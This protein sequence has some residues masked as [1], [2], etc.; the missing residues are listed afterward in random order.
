L[1]LVSLF[2]FDF[3]AGW[4][5]YESRLSTDPPVTVER[6]LPMPRFTGADW[7]RSRRLAVWTEQGIGDQVLYSTVVPDLEARGLSFVLEC[8]SRLASAFARAHPS[9]RVVTPEESGKA[10][11]ECDFH[12]PLA[13]LAGLVRPS[14]ASFARQPTRLLTPDPQRSGQARR[15]L[16]RPGARL[17]AISWRSFQPKGRDA[18]ARQKSAPLEAFRALSLRRDLQL[19]DVQ[20]GDTAAEREAFTRSGGRLAR[21]EGLD[22]FNDLEGVLAA[23]EACDLVITT[24]NVTAHFAG[25]L[26]KATWLVHLGAHPP[27]FYWVPGPSGRSLW[28]PSVE[29]V[30]VPSA[31]SWHEIFEEVA[32]RLD[33]WERT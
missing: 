20:Y 15:A 33:L 26:G 10:F 23:I 29:V 9:W 14:T 19:V 2:G 13:S 32:A 12:V 24:S 4:P 11:A 31:S 18:L 1:S 3:A 28:Y 5:L 16:D 7:E 27:F 6:L 21:I 30:A 25:A 17:A 8:D 22:L